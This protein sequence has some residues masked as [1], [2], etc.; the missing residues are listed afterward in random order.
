MLAATSPPEEK[1]DNDRE[2]N[3]TDDTVPWDAPVDGL[4]LFKDVYNILGRVMWMS[5]TARMTVTF[6][7]I[8]SVSSY[9]F[10]RLPYLR[11]K[12]P[13]RNCGKSTLIDLLAELLFKPLI[14][15]DVS[16]AAL[17]RLA[18]AAQPTILLDEFDNPEQI[19]DLTNCSTP[20]TTPTGSP[21]A[22]MPTR[23]RW[24]AFAHSVQ[25]SSPP[26]SASPRPPKV[27][28]CHRHAARA[29]GRRTEP[30]GVV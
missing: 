10:R 23:E 4:V 24:S 5:D 8:A 6:W 16:P 21:S 30:D 2:V 20:A 12:S 17:Y 18:E 14:S 11:I 19:K 26:S 22:A 9:V 1:T 28:A 27:A 29:G 7:I 3:I 15:A 13:D 25:R